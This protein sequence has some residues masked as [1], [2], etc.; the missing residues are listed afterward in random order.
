M[1]TATR[2]RQASQ[3]SRAVGAHARATIPTNGKVEGGSF[4]RWWSSSSSLTS[5][6]PQLAQFAISV[7]LLLASLSFGVALL[8]DVS[9]QSSGGACSVANFFRGGRTHGS[10]GSSLASGD[11]GRFSVTGALGEWFP[12][13]FCVGTVSLLL[14]V[15]GSVVPP[16]AFNRFAALA[17]R[18]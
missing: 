2:D 1:L 7:S 11:R 15:S 13:S 17:F 12:S 14:V 8:Q 6:D 16:S 10:S 4:T 5:S 18:A 3:H 9:S